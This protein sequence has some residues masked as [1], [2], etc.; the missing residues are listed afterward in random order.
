MDDPISVLAAKLGRTGKPLTEEKASAMD[1]AIFCSLAFKLHE[2]KTDDDASQLVAAIAPAGSVFDDRA[3]TELASRGTSRFRTVTGVDAKMEAAGMGARPSL[4]ST[5]R[6]YADP[7]LLNY[8]SLLL[9]APVP[10]KWYAIPAGSI[11][12]EAVELRRVTSAVYKEPE[13]VG[14]RER[15]D[16]RFVTAVRLDKGNKRGYDV[17]KGGSGWHE[18][19]VRGNIA[20]PLFQEEARKAEAGI[21]PKPL[22]YDPGKLDIIL[23]GFVIPLTNTA[24]S[25]LMKRGIHVS[26]TCSICGAGPDKIQELAILD[27]ESTREMKRTFRAP[28]VGICPACRDEHG[29]RVVEDKL[30]KD[31]AVVQWFLRDHDELGKHSWPFDAL[32][33]ELGAISD[34]AK[35]LLNE[36]IDYLENG[37]EIKLTEGSGYLFARGGTNVIYE[38][39]L[40]PGQCKE[41][42]KVPTDDIDGKRIRVRLYPD[43]RIVLSK[44]KGSLVVNE[45]CRKCA[46]RYAVTV[47]DY[48]RVTTY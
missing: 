44:I 9:P 37:H 27:E 30:A 23:P 47:H 31:P 29:I 1:G 45:I 33:K 38:G 12:G 4:A 43:T 42:G 8:D 6:V 22:D 18:Q 36:H 35:R 14:Q 26:V 13:Q 39:Q 2:G 21:K 32:A 24:V 40:D 25:A 5:M 34:R 7:S 41:C 3:I 28:V 15:A 20:A 48:D 16:T 11:K 19:E 46:E 10:G 17:A